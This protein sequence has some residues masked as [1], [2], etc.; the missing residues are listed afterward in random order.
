MVA[1]KYV[2]TMTRDKTDFE[3]LSLKSGFLRCIYQ[4]IGHPAQR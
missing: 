3:F 2:K 1:K 4:Q